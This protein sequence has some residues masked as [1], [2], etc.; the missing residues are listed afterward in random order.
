MVNEVP[1]LEAVGSGAGIVISGFYSVITNVI[2]MGIVL[3]LLLAV[4]YALMQWNRFRTC[5]IILY[6]GGK[7]IVRS[8][9]IPL[10]D[11]SNFSIKVGKTVRGYNLSKQEPMQ[12]RKF[13]GF[14]PMY[15]VGENTPL[16][17]DFDIDTSSFS[18]GEDPKTIGKM[19]DGTFFRAMA[20][21]SA[22]A[23]KVDLLMIAIGIAVGFALLFMLS[24]MGIVPLCSGGA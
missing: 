6:I 12:V 2:F 16:G 17:I 15:I 20:S 9:Q 19:V 22:Q 5:A 14:Q 4:A 10:M 13:W 8:V 18:V 23:G 24:N 1:I 7:K 3:P 11:I 21:A